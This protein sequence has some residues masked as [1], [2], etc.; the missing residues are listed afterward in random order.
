VRDLLD[1]AVHGAELGKALL[2][3]AGLG[4]PAQEDEALTPGGEHRDVGLVRKDPFT[5]LSDLDE[6]RLRVE[7]GRGR[8]R[9]RVVVRGGRNPVLGSTAVSVRGGEG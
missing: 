5:Q 9:G 4:D 8:S 7:G 6:C 1:G 3:G 2:V